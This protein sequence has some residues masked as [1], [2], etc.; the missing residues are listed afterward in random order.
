MK[1]EVQNRGS[2]HAHIAL[3]LSDEDAERVGNEIVGVLPGEL[4]PDGEV[5]MPPEELNGG[6][7]ADL[8]RLVKRKLL[9]TCRQ[10][11]CIKPGQ[12]CKSGFPF[13][14]K[15]LRKSV[16]DDKTRRHLYYR[17]R[18]ADR[19]VVPYHPAILLDWRGHINLQVRKPDAGSPP[20]P[21]N[22]T[23]CQVLL[24]LSPTAAATAARAPSCPP[25]LLAHSSR[26]LHPAP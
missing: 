14:I 19:Q 10:G 24:L 20:P 13:D 16:L 6:A 2:L 12:P 22:C 9:H 15:P 3:W 8:H 7:D 5:V 26:A 1:Y 25:L 21:R 23:T 17:P 4:G 11:M 18:H